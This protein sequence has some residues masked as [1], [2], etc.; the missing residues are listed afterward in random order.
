MVE[1]ERS[2][3]SIGFRGVEEYRIRVVGL[4][5]YLDKT[6]FNRAILDRIAIDGI[7]FDRIVFDILDCILL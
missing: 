4:N 6:I 5:G 3:G 7:V 2:I 1:N